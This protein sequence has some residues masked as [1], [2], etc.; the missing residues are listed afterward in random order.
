[1][2]ILHVAAE[3]APYVTIGGLSQVM[4]FLPK[5]QKKLGLDVRVFTPKY[6]DTKIAKTEKIEHPLASSAA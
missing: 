1:M 3:V 2:K 4:Y 6:G 5:A